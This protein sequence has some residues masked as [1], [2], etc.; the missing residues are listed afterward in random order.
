MENQWNLP[1][2]SANQHLVI[3]PSTV[4]STNVFTLRNKLFTGVTLSNVSIN[5]SRSDD[6]S[7]TRLKD[8]FHRLVP[9]TVAIQQGRCY[10]AQCLKNSLQPWRKVEIKS[11]F[12][13]GF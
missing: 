11:T 9:Q 7:H 4:I 3:L 12:R 1:S 2:V 10:T 5:L 8:H 6:H 13:N